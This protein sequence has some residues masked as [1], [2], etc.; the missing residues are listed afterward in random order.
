MDGDGIPLA[1]D[2][3]EGNKN[4]QVTLKPLEERIIKDFELNIFYLINVIQLLADKHD[5]QIYSYIN[6]N[7]IKKNR[8]SRHTI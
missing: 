5:K 7:N 4:K 2:I 1:F 3:Y 8:I 6:I